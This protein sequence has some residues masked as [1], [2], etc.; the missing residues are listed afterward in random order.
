[1]KLTNE[2]IAKIAPACCNI[3]DR[4][5]GVRFVDGRTRMGPW[6]DMCPTC[7]ARY[8]VGLGTGRGQLYELQADGRYVKVSG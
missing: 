2:A 4:P 3:C 7:H 8:G 6:A 5:V 1:M